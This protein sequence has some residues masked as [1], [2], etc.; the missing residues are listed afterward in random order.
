MERTLSLGNIKYYTTFLLFIMGSSLA[1][2]ILNVSLSAY[3]CD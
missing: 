1:T 2:V 3:I